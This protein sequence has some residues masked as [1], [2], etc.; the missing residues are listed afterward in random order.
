MKYT[1]IFIFLFICVSCNKALDEAPD[2]KISI[3]D[4]FKDNTK[5]GA[6]LNSCY[7][8]MPGKGT[9]YYFW[10]RGPGYYRN[11]LAKSRMVGKPKPH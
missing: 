11:Q 6:F 9:L 8:Y 2:G 4:V 1:I 7:A 3:D 10:S 5:V